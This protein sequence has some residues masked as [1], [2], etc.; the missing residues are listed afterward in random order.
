MNPDDVLSIFKET[1][2]LLEGHFLLTSGLHSDQYFQCAKVLQ[3]PRHC[4]A[5]CRVIAEHFRAGHIDVV[6][7]PAMGGI[8]VGQEVGRHLGVRTI[9]AERKDGAM[10]I[11]R[12]FEIGKGER[13]LVC[14][15][16]VTTGGSVNEVIRLVLERQ[17]VLAG[18]ACIVDRSG[19]AVRFEG[20]PEP[21]VPVL[22]MNA[23]TYKPEA[24]PLC[25]QGIPAVKPG[26]RGNA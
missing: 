2:A 19:G 5:L 18:V 8:V 1:G 6:I 12:G 4:E 24:C 10:Q 26:S 15:D 20:A 23:V 22:R 11:R 17:G 21:L 16:V 7:A 3:H 9:F 13:V 25:A 14:E